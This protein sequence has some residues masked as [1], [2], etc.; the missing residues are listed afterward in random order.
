MM[1]MTMRTMPTI[2][3]GFIGGN[4]QRSAALDQIDNQHHNRNDE[5]DVNES[6][7][8]IRANQS[9]QPEH[10]QNHEYCP[11]HKIPF[12]CVLPFFAR[13]GS[14]A[15][16]GLKILITCGASNPLQS[17]ACSVAYHSNAF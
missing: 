14:V 3:A 2:A 9:K 7:Q 1:P 15:L 11:E 13:D 17:P 8:R 6:A 4:L 10:K 12:G 16:I 5:Q